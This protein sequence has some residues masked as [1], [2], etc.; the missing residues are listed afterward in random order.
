VG[1]RGQVTHHTVGSRNRVDDAL[2]DGLRPVRP[3]G[4]TAARAPGRRLDEL[5]GS[6]IG[7]RPLSDAASPRDRPTGHQA[8]ALGE[9]QTVR[10]NLWLAAALLCTALIDGTAHAAS[11]SCRESDV[12]V[13]GS[14]SA[15]RETLCSAAADAF[16]FLERY[17][18]EPKRAIRIEI[19]EQSIHHGGY[20]AYGSYDVTSD[21]IYLM[22]YPAVL[23]SS[24]QPRMYGE[25]FDRVHYR[26]AIA[27]EVAHAVVEHNSRTSP[28]SKAAQEYLAHATQ[29]AVLPPERRAAII[30]AAGVGAWEPGDAISEIYMAFAPNRFAVKS[31]LHL[32]GLEDPAP[33][34]ETLLGAKWF[35]VYVE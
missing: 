17:G 10:A 13:Q 30:R 5:P 6:T 33:F 12:T 8:P 27:H 7:D 28:L 18:L 19:V 32:T 2:P 9:E 22:S 15:A 25:P 4:S 23:A 26:G 21:R 34:V 1:P 31:Y 3:G 16:A 20:A 11:F 14:S 24:E 35:Y 29:L